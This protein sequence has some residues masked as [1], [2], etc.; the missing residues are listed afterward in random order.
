MGKRVRAGSSLGASNNPLAREIP[1]VVFRTA[2]GAPMQTAAH[3]GE[4]R[5]IQEVIEE[6]GSLDRDT[7]GGTIKGVL[8]AL[9]IMG[10][11]YAVILWVLM[12]YSSN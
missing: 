1:N 6:A 10:P 9:A 2:Q 8:W 4:L 3:E 11:I 7:D 12:S 5:R